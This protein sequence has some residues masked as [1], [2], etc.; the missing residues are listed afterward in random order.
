MSGLSIH[1][2]ENPQDRPHEFLVRDP[3]VT[4]R[5]SFRK[6]GG[7]LNP[8]VRIGENNLA[9]IEEPDVASIVD[10]LRRRYLNNAFYTYIGDVL[11]YMPP[12]SGISMYTDEDVQYYC[13]N[14]AFDPDLKP[15][16]YS[17]A[18][19]VYSNMLFW[20]RNQVV[21]MSGSS[22][23][24]KTINTK[25][26]LSYIQSVSGGWDLSV[27]LKTRLA[28]LFNVLDCFG[29]AQ[30]ADSIYASKYTSQ[31]Q[32][33]FNYFGDIIS[34]QLKTC[35]LE[36]SRVC[37]PP[38]GESNF[39]IFH[40]LMEH[41]GSDGAAYPY[42]SNTSHT[43]A[44]KVTLPSIQ[45]S[46]VALGMPEGEKEHVINILTAILILGQIQYKTEGDGVGVRITNPAVVKVIAKLL[47]VTN[48]SMTDM[49]TSTP[50]ISGNRSIMMNP[51]SYDK[52]VSKR[53]A[54]ASYLYLRLFNELLMSANKSLAGE[55]P[56][57][58][59]EE[60]CL[61]MD[62]VD[63]YGIKGGDSNN[64]AV[65][66]CNYSNEKLHQCFIESAL[67]APQE[68]Y[69]QEGL[70]WDPIR[71]PDNRGTIGLFTELQP[72]SLTECIEREC[73]K[74]GDTTNFQA[75]EA[76][77][78]ISSPYFMLSHEVE[79]EFIVR[80]Y[81]GE[82]SYDATNFHKMAKTGLPKDCKR[83]MNSSKL[84][85]LQRMFPDG[86]QSEWMKGKS[87]M[88]V[89]QAYV[90]AIDNLLKDL[91]NKFL[92]FVRCI[93]PN[94]S[95]TPQLFED[96]IVED[97]VRSSC[98]VETAL[99]K[100]RGFAF[101]SDL[102]GFVQRYK[103][104]HE[105][106]RFSR[107][108]GD[109][110][111]AADRICGNL[112]IDMDLYFVGFTCIFIKDSATVLYLEK[113]RDECIDFIVT[114]IQLCWKRRYINKKLGPHLRAV[115]ETLAQADRTKKIILPKLQGPFS[116][117]INGYLDR[118][119]R[120]WW[121][122]CLIKSLKKSDRNIVRIAII[123]HSA[124]AGELS[125]NPDLL[126]AGIHPSGKPMNIHCLRMRSNYITSENFDGS[127]LLSQTNE[128]SAHGKRILFTAPINRLNRKHVVER[129]Y[130]VLTD[131]ALIFL[132]TKF[133][134]YPQ[135]TIFLKNVQ[136]LSLSTHVDT[137]IVIHQREAGK[138][139]V[140]DFGVTG[141]Y[142]TLPEFVGNLFLACK[143][144]GNRIPVNV[145]VDRIRY[146]NSRKP[147]VYDELSFS[148]KKEKST[149]LK[150]GAPLCTLKNKVV[151]YYGGRDV[152]H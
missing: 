120:C 1:E 92:S 5:S 45:D 147:D 126:K 88:C 39:H 80:H 79:N 116:R 20:K 16:I 86:A 15:H 24:G 10:N 54:L 4:G 70:D 64:F 78:G 52:A 152:L 141:I 106:D 40:L 68:L 146:N 117:D 21:M 47:G 139:M 123:A 71:I 51:L 30:T 104:T 128:R 136:Q 82:V 26:F 46:L 6:K 96:D 11:I 72:E 133:E 99:I 27:T 35:L 77:G 14:N 135:K 28:H 12:F 62:I 140:L 102:V 31:L 134:L 58:Q 57:K 105:E 9:D 42:L 83:V 44:L 101:S 149:K 48:S 130:V 150:A 148:A 63:G 121:A 119:Y 3:S 69:L 49:L 53:N 127:A 89:A 145:Y 32:L 61:T 112:Q 110:Q 109:W 100:Q 41:I 2:R 19:R 8:I 66:C 124:F 113:K 7:I 18:D 111:M 118:I 23:S 131:K 67:T 84:A 55:D 137:M 50:H 144:L 65:L 138:D 91:K 114:K 13:E 93:K 22:G 108:D 56:E 97:Q 94:L 37:G 85:L 17:F 29:S 36:K 122:A 76:F 38:Q 75:D 90:G 33:K 87:S 142:H 115:R 43:F 95:S 59:M 132:T 143:K 125:D 34:C 25:Q 60:L 73:N 98:L 81:I 151:I 74:P 129:G 103:C 107:C